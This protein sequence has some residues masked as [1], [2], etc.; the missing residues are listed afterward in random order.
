[1]ATESFKQLRLLSDSVGPSSVRDAGYFRR[2][3]HFRSQAAS[4]LIGSSALC[5]AAPRRGSAVPGCACASRALAFFRG[6][7]GA[8]EPALTVSRGAVPSWGASGARGQRESSCPQPRAGDGCSFRSFA[9]P[10]EEPPGKPLSFEE[11]EK[12]PGVREG[13]TRN[14]DAFSRIVGR[15]LCPPPTRGALTFNL[16]SLDSG[17]P[18]E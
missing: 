8:R 18:R 1:M 7:A 16:C 11:K 15:S 6:V 10:M 9:G 3:L 13:L 2:V 12:V 14:S 5:E 4:G 17:A